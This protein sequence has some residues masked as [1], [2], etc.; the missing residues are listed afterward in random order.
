MKMKKFVVYNVLGAILWST[1][2]P[3][4]GDTLG[5]RIKNIDK[6]LLPIVIAAVL[7][8]FLP[9]IWHLFLRKDKSNKPQQNSNLE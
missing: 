8:S 3:I 2:I 1:I 4:L 5:H 6:Y 9:A 7:V